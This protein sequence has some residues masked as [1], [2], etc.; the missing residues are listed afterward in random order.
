MLILGPLFK[1]AATF[2]LFKALTPREAHE[3]SHSDALDTH[4]LDELARTDGGPTS[5]ESDESATV[6]ATSTPATSTPAT[7][8]PTST[9]AVPAHWVPVTDARLAALASPATTSTPASSS[10]PSDSSENFQPFTEQELATEAATVASTTD[11]ESA[12]NAARSLHAYVM[13]TPSSRRDRQYI[14]VLQAAMGRITADGLIG[15]ETAA[16]IKALTG[17]RIPGLS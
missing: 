8:T 6:P 4:G 5:I 9:P 14:R 2:L 15:R 17:L 16:R 3:E 13:R 7:S 12:V 11:D 10:S 1:A